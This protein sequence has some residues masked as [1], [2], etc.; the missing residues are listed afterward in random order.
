M[1]IRLVLAL[2]KIH[3]ELV[4]SNTLRQKESYSYNSFISSIMEVVT[5]QKTLIKKQSEFLDYQIAIVKAQNKIIEK[6]KELLDDKI[7]SGNSS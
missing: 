6:Q 3:D 7:A 1:N 5:E 4:T 2:E